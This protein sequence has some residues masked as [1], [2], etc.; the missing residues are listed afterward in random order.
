MNHP[1]KVRRI[2]VPTQRRKRRCGEVSGVRIHSRRHGEQREDE[3]GDGGEDG[4]RGPEPVRLQVD[5]EGGA[6]VH[7]QT[8]S[9]TGTH[10]GTKTCAM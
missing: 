4:R 6:S 5:E 2:E 10:H 8:S 9:W 1:Q 7:G 3:E